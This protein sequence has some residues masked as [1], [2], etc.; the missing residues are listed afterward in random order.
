MTKTHVYTKVRKIYLWILTLIFNINFK[1]VWWFNKRLHVVTSK[2]G[3]Y[4][5][6]NL[7]ILLIWNTVVSY[8]IPIMKSWRLCYLR[9]PYQNCF[10]NREIV[11][12]IDGYDG[13][14]FFSRAIYVIRFSFCL[15][16]DW[17]RSTKILV[18]YFFLYIIFH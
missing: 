14:G 9:P 2:V 16:E 3:R 6:L 1:I 18:Y 13:V 17:L 12:R 7:S 5:L 4:T 11:S 10:S 15:W 8:W